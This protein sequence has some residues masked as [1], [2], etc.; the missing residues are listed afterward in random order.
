MNTCKISGKQFQITEEDKAFHDKVGLPLPE[1]APFERLRE[2]LMWRNEVEFYRNKCDLTGKPLISVFRPE[3]KVTLYNTRDFWSDKWN[4][5]DYGMDFDFNRPFFEQFAEL[6]AQVPQLPLVNDDGIGSSN[7]EYTNDTTHSKNCYFTFNSFYLE[8]VLYSYFA[9][10]SKSC[11]DCLVAQENQ[12]CFEC[13][14]TQKSYNCLYLQKS[15]NCNNCYVSYDLQAC[16]NCFGCFGLVNKSYCLYNQQ[17]TKEEFDKFM[18]E[19]DLSAELQ[20]FADFIKDKPKKHLNI[21]NSENCIGDNIVN[22]KNSLGFDVNKIQ[23][24][25]YMYCIYDAKDCQDIFSSGYCELCYRS[26]MPDHCYQV[27]FSINTTDSKFCMYT[28]LCKS[29]QNLFGCCS[30][31]RGKNVILNKAYSVQEY[32]DMMLKIKGH[33]QETGEWGQFFPARY[34]PFAYNETCAQQYLPMNKEEAL[35]RS[36]KWLDKDM[37]LFDGAS[38]DLRKCSVSGRLFKVTPLEAKLYKQWGVELPNLCFQERHKARFA[39][40]NPWVL[41]TQDCVKCSKTVLT[42]YQD[43]TV[44]CEDCYLAEKY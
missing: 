28:S 32:D 38:P 31:K 4:P 9:D 37:E 42:S 13:V 2:M 11:V 5:L 12:L 27:H 40:R 34:S 39:K 36:Y 44:V 16:E 14:D 22:S 29:S 17:V 24:S 20:K 25:R 21:K 41:H 10:H 18:A 15:E 30:V 8:D 26:L 6:Y 7:C 35:S 19:Y 43:S 33:M 23:D 3:T 1:L